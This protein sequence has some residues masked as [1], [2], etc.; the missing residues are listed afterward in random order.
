MTISPFGGKILFYMY[1][2]GDPNSYSGAVADGISGPDI[3]ELVKGLEEK[4]DEN[5]EFYS[6]IKEIYYANVYEILHNAFHIKLNS[7]DFQSQLIKKPFYV[8]AGEHDDIPRMVY[9]IVGIKPVTES[10]LKKSIKLSHFNRNGKKL[11]YIAKSEELTNALE[12]SKFVI[13]PSLGIDGL[14]AFF[15]VLVNNTLLKLNTA[16]NNKECCSIIKAYAKAFEH[17]EI[18]L[19]DDS[20]INLIGN[21][22][23]CVEKD[24]ECFNIITGTLLPKKKSRLVQI[25]FNL[26]CAYAIH[27]YRI[28]ALYYVKVYLQHDGSIENLLSDSWLKSLKADINNLRSS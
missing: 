24:K 13:Q 7:H 15:I 4:L 16:G 28:E 2:K 3:S 11:V 23:C 12:K 20:H 6:E 21:A 1:A 17:L 10:E 9:T 18:D 14:G 5:E 26:A 22:L 27:R 8:L 25:S 19:N